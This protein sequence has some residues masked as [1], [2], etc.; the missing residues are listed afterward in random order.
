MIDGGPDADRVSYAERTRPVTV[1]LGRHSVSGEAG[2][3]DVLDGI[4]GAS[5]GTGDDILIGTSGP[6]TLIGGGGDDVIEGR[7]G[8]DVL[9]DGDPSSERADRDRLDGGAGP[10]IVG[11]RHRTTGVTVDLRRG[12][13]DGGH[14]ESDRL[15]SIE[16]AIGGA[17][18]DRLA[19]D[20]R[21]NRLEGGPGNDVLEGRAGGDY[22]RGGTGFNTIRGGAGDDRISTFKDHFEEGVDRAS[23]GPGRDIV[24]NPSRA[25]VA[26]DCERVSF[27]DARTTYRAQ[28]TRVTQGTVSFRV[29]CTHRAPRCRGSVELSTPT[30]SPWYRRPPFDQTVGAQTSFTAR[31]GSSVL[32]R[33]PLTSV[34]RRLVQRPGQ[35]PF[36]VFL[37]IGMPDHQDGGDDGLWS[38][39]L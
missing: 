24:L 37:D 30:R 18:A 17:G 29:R 22:L 19:G 20:A 34:G 26:R 28:P 31:S 33:V 27:F 39:F 10:D 11:F 38:V 25:F 21:S 14:G 32:V 35:R 13:S 36:V 1:R 4:E 5:G 7:A 23:C 15:L 2:E 16:G 3:N 6:D 9:S 8:N 12:R